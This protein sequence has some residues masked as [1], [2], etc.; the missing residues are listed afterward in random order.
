MAKTQE[1]TPQQATDDS[2]SPL[3]RVVHNSLGSGTVA[4]A[5]GESA[6][7]AFLA[8][9]GAIATDHAMTVSRVIA[10]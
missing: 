5:D 9:V 3:W 4:A 2:G 7:A 8:S 10:E 1:K 6:K